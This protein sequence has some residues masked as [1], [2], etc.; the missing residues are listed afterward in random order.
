[1]LTPFQRSLDL[2]TIYAKA[3]PAPAPTQAPAQA[4]TPAPPAPLPARLRIMSWN[5]GRGHDP[6][7][8]ADAIAAAAPDVACL[9]EAD[10]GNERTGGRDVL[11][12]LAARTGM[13]GLFGIEF[14]E[15]PS[16]RRPRSLRGGGATG[17]ALLCRAVPGAPRRIEL[18]PALDWR[19]GAADPRLPGRVRRRLE[20]EARIGGRFA[21][22]AEVACAGG[23][24]TVCCTHLE[25]KFGGVRGRF[26]QFQAIC[27]ALA[28]CPGAVVVAG[29]FNTFDSRLARLAAPEGAATALGKP[30]GATEAQWWKA[31][32]LPP[33]GFADPFDAS[34]W[35]FCVPPF[36]RAKLDW[37]AVKG[38]S[39][40]ARSRGGF[41]SSDHR[42]VWC[43]VVHLR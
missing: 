18:P 14:L 11:Q 22:A 9:Q 43:D 30:P 35:T 40:L 2:G 19:H 36:F 31:H 41:A 5:I 33:T 34:D 37:I 7:R 1:M 39:V 42:P 20:R 17:N 13:A 16:V 3:A 29:D 8:I 32:L 24:V 27:G 12:E 38:A 21:L 25:D 10:W 6:A 23:A 28:G 15:L 26:R 4:P